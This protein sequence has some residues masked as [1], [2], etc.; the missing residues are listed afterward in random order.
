VSSD[1]TIQR[2]PSGDAQLHEPRNL[3]PSLN[4]LDE[5]QRH[6]HNGTSDSQLSG[7]SNGHD[8]SVGKAQSPLEPGGSQAPLESI[9]AEEV[10]PDDSSL[11][12]L[13][14]TLGLANST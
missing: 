14:T 7:N 5:N 2:D 6:H 10:L 4:N 1:S 9:D 11:T 3:S 8:H 12:Y 13:G